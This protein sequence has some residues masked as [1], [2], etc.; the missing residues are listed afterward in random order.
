MA[1]SKVA[2]G[3]SPMKG[4][5]PLAALV[6]GALLYHGMRNGQRRDL[7]RGTAVQDARQ[8]AV[9]QRNAGMNAALRGGAQLEG[10]GSVIYNNERAANSDIGDLYMFDKGASALMSAAG[11]LL[12]KQAGIGGMALS[13]L[14]KLNKAPDLAV[15]ATQWAGKNTLGKLPSMGWKGT[16]AV[17]AGLLGAGYAAA[18]GGKAL[19]NYGMRPAEA[20]ALGGHHAELPQYVNQYGSMT[21]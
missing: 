16:A 15:K 12:A 17:G 13:A 19:Y 5:L 3:W 8:V 18:K 14:G 9:A 21:G 7:A 10:P 2:E 6:G 11:E 4:G 20:H 1:Q